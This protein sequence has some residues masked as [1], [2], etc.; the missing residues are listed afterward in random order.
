MWK[1]MLVLSVLD[2]DVYLVR[3]GSCLCCNVGLQ[4]LIFAPLTASFSNQRTRVTVGGPWVEA[5]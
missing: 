4:A 1:T 5:V 3:R 2:Y